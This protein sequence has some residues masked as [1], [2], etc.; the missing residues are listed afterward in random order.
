V[1]EHG[2]GYR[3]TTYRGLLAADLAAEGLNYVS[4]PSASVQCDGALLGEARCDCL[5]LQNRIGVLV[6]ALRKS[7]TAADRAILQTYPRLLHLPLGL[8]LNFGKSSLEHHWIFRS[9]HHVPA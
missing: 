3:D 5:A 7:V 1:S 6:L 9:H 2:F 8:I 4:T